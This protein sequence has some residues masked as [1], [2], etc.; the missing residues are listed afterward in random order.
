LACASDA[1]A[2]RDPGTQGATGHGPA[3]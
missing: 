1:A 3:C 2:A